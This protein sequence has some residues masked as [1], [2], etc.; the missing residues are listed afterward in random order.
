MRS[1]NI[2]WFNIEGHSEECFQWFIGGRGIGKTYSALSLFLQ[3]GKVGIYLRTTETEISIACSEEG[4]VFK[5]ISRDHCINIE[6]SGYD[7]KKKLGT[8]T[9]DGQLIGYG[10][11][12]STFG[13]VRGIDLSDVD[14]IVYDEVVPEKHIR[15][16][17]DAGIAFA[18]AYESINRN[19]ELEGRPPIRVYFLANSISLDNDV[20]LAQGI[21]Q[22]IPKMLRKNMREYTDKDR[23]LYVTL[24]PNKVSEQKRETAIY[25]LMRDTSFSDQALDNQFADDALQLECKVNLR[26]YNP[27]IKYDN[28]VCYRHKSKN[29]LYFSRG[30]N[31]PLSYKRDQAQSF[32]SKFRATYTL[33]VMRDHAY[34]AEYDIK[35]ILDRMFNI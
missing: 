28:I 31:A 30:G 8:Y 10:I 25:K 22:L 15:R 12:L 13:R 27:I 32:K 7:E 14:F 2:E 20:M 34:F 1:S 16:V 29:V 18:N 17:T 9:L 35:L 4:N 3:P 6:A 23:L 11:A 26:E 21:C 24:C 19:R 5:R 33:A